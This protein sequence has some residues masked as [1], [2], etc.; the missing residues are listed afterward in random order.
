MKQRSKDKRKFRSI[1]EFKKEFFPKSSAE[2]S[3]E[4]GD[5]P[6][7]FGAAR[8]EKILEEVE[9]QLSQSSFNTSS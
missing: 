5:D 3:A 6:E 1:E 4:S 8:A 7:S 2:Q 9:A